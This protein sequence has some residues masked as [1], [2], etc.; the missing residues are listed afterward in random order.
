[1]INSLINTLHYFDPTID[2]THS[3]FNKKLTPSEMFI[4]VLQADFTSNVSKIIRIATICFSICAFLAPTTLGII[5][6]VKVIALPAPYLLFKVATLGVVTLAVYKI[7]YEIGGFVESSLK[8]LKQLHQENRIVKALG[9]QNSIKSLTVLKKEELEKI[10]QNNEYVDL[11]DTKI[12]SNIKPE[13]VPFQGLTV[14]YLPNNGFFICMHV[15]KKLE[16]NKQIEDLKLNSCI[17]LLVYTNNSWKFL[18][19][20]N[21]AKKVYSILIPGLETNIKNIRFLCKGTHSTHELVQKINSLIIQRPTH[22][23]DMSIYCLS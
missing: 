2:L 8:T 15:K 5:L 10:N 19:K 20:K 22:F 3:Y 4:R 12:V 1:M 13:H 18:Y 21:P 11:F 16:M 7:Y 6:A 9:N 23:A 14:G 17:R